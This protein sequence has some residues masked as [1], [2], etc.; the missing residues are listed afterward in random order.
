MHLYEDADFPAQPEHLSPV[1]S[2]APRNPFFFASLRLSISERS[3]QRRKNGLL[4]IKISDFC[5]ATK[6][7]AGS[8]L[9]LS[10]VLIANVNKVCRQLMTKT[11]PVAMAL[12]RWAQPL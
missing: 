5:L 2:D 8:L 11:E 7:L 3:K 9:P 6:P 10:N 4:C 12:E 1:H